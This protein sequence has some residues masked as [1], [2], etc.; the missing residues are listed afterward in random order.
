MKN[1]TW[2]C[3]LAKSTKILSESGIS[4]Q[5]VSIFYSDFVSIRLEV[6]LAMKDVLLWGL[7]V[8]LK[9]KE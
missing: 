9:K 5:S 3:F 2:H 1:L 8:Q 4:L 6:S 7:D